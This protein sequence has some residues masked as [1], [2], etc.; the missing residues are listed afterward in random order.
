MKV[1]V[2]LVAAAG[3]LLATGLALGASS[4][5]DDAGDEN[6][7]PDITSVRVSDSP[8]E[9]FTVTLGIS[10][11]DSLPPDSWF[12]VWFDVDSDESTGYAGDERLVRYLST[13]D[14]ELYEWDGFAM[15]RR[16][17]PGGL[18]G[19]Y[20]AG[21]LVLTVP[22]ATLGDD[23]RFGVL[24]ISSRRQ[25][26]ILS[27]FVASDIAPDNGRAAYTGPVAA[28]FA[29]REDDQDAAPDIAG[30][31][32]VDR[33][34][35]WISFAVTTPNYTTLPDESAFWVALDTDNRAATSDVDA[36]PELQI[37]Y[38]R[39][40]IS[41][42]RWEARNGGWVQVPGDLVRAR[43]AGNVVTIEIRRSAVGSARRFGFSFTT[44]DFDSETGTVRALDLAPNSG[45][46]Y[47][48]TLANTAVTLQAARIVSVPTVPRAGRS[49]AVSLP[50]IRSDTGRPIRSGAVACAASLAGTKLS[51]VGSVARGAARCVFSI[52]GSGAGA[53][54]RGTV[55][56][57]SAGSTLARPF[58]YVVG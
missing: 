18:R 58:A 21:T 43:N 20:A 9:T 13:G 38:V 24:A 44:A 11:Y 42:E 28:T 49:F 40:D 41:L 51:G 48:Y 12:N 31:R 14:V 2:V 50:V 55:T 56:V 37:P 19:S 16:P 32:V 7:A 1:S 23:S 46:F 4:F 6:A 57:R 34:D 5:S 30:V 26:V 45:G 47:R 15:L 17:A 25:A 8:D 53:R 10:N 29:D 52:P 35:G 36:A 22:R 39:G 27:Q 33:K 54:L 3:A